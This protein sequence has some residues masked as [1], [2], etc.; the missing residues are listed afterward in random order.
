MESAL[1]NNIENRKFIAT[2][3]FKCV[4]IRLKKLVITAFV[5]RQSLKEKER[6]AS[7]LKSQIPGDSRTIS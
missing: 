4:F 6:A 7:C 2:V 5:N 3:E 1:I